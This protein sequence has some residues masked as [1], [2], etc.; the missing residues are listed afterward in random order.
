MK[1][2]NKKDIKAAEEE[3]EETF[4]GLQQARQQVDFWTD[5]A[6]S[7]VGRLNLLNE[8]IGDQAEEPKKEPEKSE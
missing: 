1:L 3:R 8:Q 7:L 6:K 5:R 4:T 2:T